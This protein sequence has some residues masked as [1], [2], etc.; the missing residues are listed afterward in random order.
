MKNDAAVTL[1]FSS[2]D[3]G[4]HDRVVIQELLKEVA[5]AQS[6]D[7]SHKEFKGMSKTN[8]HV[9]PSSQSVLLTL[10]SCGVD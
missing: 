5:Q 2:S 4:F 3:A 6:L 1:T 10:N 8:N 7:M 9:I